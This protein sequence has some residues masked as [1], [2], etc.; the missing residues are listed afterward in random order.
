MCV[1]WLGHWRPFNKERLVWIA[2]AVRPTWLWSRETAWT[3]YASRATQRQSGWDG[4]RM[5]PVSSHISPVSFW[6][7]RQPL[8]VC[9]YLSHPHCFTALIYILATDKQI[10]PR[11]LI[12]DIKN[13]SPLFPTVGYVKTT[14]VEIDFNSL[15]SHKAPQTYE[16]EVY[17][18]IDVL[19]LNNRY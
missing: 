4:R 7:V 11:I 17:D 18:D 3:S 6:P 15:K 13:Y 9:Y 16:P 2:E 8:P 12:E 1:S 5:D 14:L 19:S 10:R